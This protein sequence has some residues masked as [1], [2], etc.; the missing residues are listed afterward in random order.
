M[1]LSFEES[2]RMASKSVMTTSFMAIQN[3]PVVADVATMD[4][5]D[6]AAFAAVDS[7]F[8]R[9]DKYV[10]IDDYEDTVYSSIDENRN[11][12]VN[13]AQVD[14]TQENNG[15][16]VPFEMPRFYDGIDLM[17]MTIQIHYMNASNEENYAAPINVTFND[18]K[19][20]FGW[21]LSDNAT[22][23]DGTLAFELMASGAVTIPNSS[24][25]K[26]YLWRSRPNGK[27]NVIKSL[28]G[29]KMTDPTGDDWYTSFLATMNQKVGEA[30]SAAAEAKQSANDAKNAVASVDKKLAQYYKK[31]E[32]DG[33]VEMLRDEINAVDGL[34]NFDVKYTPETQIIQ[35]MNGEQEISRITLSTDPSVDWVTAYNKTVDAKIDE[36][37]SPVQ[38]TLTE[39]K[40]TLDNLKT[41]V[42]DLPTTL[43]SDYYNKGATDKLLADKAD[44][45]AVSGFTTDIANI[46]S[47]ISSIQDSVDTANSDIAEIQEKLKDFNPE[48]SG[49]EYDITYEDSKLSLLENG[50]V[51]T[52]VVIQGG[53]GGTGGT[54]VITIER[55]DG[56]ALTVIS[57]DAAIINY[58]FRSV[59][60]SGDDTGNAT[61]T[62]YVG[63]TKVATQTIVQG[64]NS[65]DITQYLH[66]GDNNIKLSVV[67][68]VGSVGT[69]TW[70]INVI[71]FYIESI[72]D[73]TLIYSDEVTFRYTPYG[74][75]S[76]T[77]VFTL[78]G[79]QVGT[80]TTT[81]TGRQ[82]TYTLPLQKHGAHLLE[83]HMTAE[84]NGNTVT[85]NKIY[86][87]IMWVSDLDTTPIISC[88]VRNY[89]TKQYSNIAITYT[90][91]D[92]SSSTARVTL[93]VDGITT[94]TLSVGRT[95]QTW[96]FKSAAI[97]THVL[98]I[99][100]GDT[101]KTIS[102]TVTELGITIEPVKTNLAFDFNPA[103]KTNA[104]ENRLWTDGNT[105]MTVSDNFDWSNG[106]YQIDEDGD[107]YFCVKSGTT[108]T[109]DYKLFADD[110][111]KSGKNFKLI[112][113]TANVRNYDA[114]AVTCLN[115]N[116]GLNI[117]AQKITLTSEQNSID[118]PTCEDDFMEFEFNILPD[119]QY[120][121]MVLWLDGIPCK[122]ELYASS[123]NFTQAKPVGI[124]IGSND[125]DVQVYRMKSY[126]MNLTDD[127]I[128]DNFIADAKNAEE[129]I[130][131]YTRND[132]TDVSGELNP[133]LLAEKCPNL[134][135]IKISAPTFTTGKKN[136]VPN[137]TI[138]HIYKNGRAVED[139]WIATG[140]HK[141]QGT[142]SNAYGESGRNI[143][144]DCSG[145]FT[146]GDESTGSKYAFTENSVGEKYFNIKVNVASSENANNALLADEFNEFN[147][148]IRQARKD[149]PKVRDTMAF[150]PC[151][152]FIQ[153]TDTTNAT[154][155]KDGQ[156]HFYACGDFGNSK[157]NSDTMGMDPNNHKEVIVEID[158]NTDAQTRFLSGDF[159]EETWDG[160]HSF[161]FRYI[162]K[163]CSE[164]EI[165]DAKNAWIRVQN[166]VVNAD[167]EEFKKN[168]ENYFVKDSALFHYL[169]TERHTMVDNR[170]KN[171]FPHTSDLVHWDF[172]FDYDNDTA[173]GNDN[174]GGL[175]LTYG[176]EDMDTIGTKS[177]FNAH[178]SKLWCKIRDLFADDLAKMFLNRESALAWSSTR[179]L[180]KFEDYQDVKP[181]RLWV[182][183]MRRK[184]FRTYEDNGTTSYL[185]MMHGNKRHQR[186]QFQR[187]QEKYMASKYTGTTCT[188][189][190]MTIRG[191]TPTNWTGVRPDGTFHITPYADTYISVRYGSNPVKMR[192]KRGQTYEVPCPIE[193]MNDTEVYIYNASIIQS[194]G[195]ISGFYP[196][197]VDFSHGIKLTDLQ[198]GSSVEGYAN[199]NMTDFAVGNNTLLE[200]LNLQNVPNL[201]KSIN[202]TG[203]VNLAEFLANGSGV[204]GVAFAKGGKIQKATLP[205]I[206]NLSVQNLRY[207]TDFSIAS[208]A[209]ITTL[210]VEDC[211]TIDLKEMLP[212]CTSLN[213]V[214][215]TGINWELSDTT[216]LDK[217]YGMTGLDENGYNSDHSV[218]EGIVHLPLIRE[219]QLENFK[220]QWPDLTIEYNTLIEQY[221]W[222][223]V[224]KDGSVLDIQYVDKGSKAVD[225]TTRTDN[226][227]S[228]PTYES[229]ISTDFTFKGWDTELAPAFSNETVTAVYTESVR[230]YHVRYMNHGNILQDTEAPYGSLVLYDGDIP[231]YTAEE[232]AFKFYLFNGWDKGGYVN[233]EKDINAVFDSC[234]Y[235]T[236]YFDGKELK[237]LR[238]VE[239][240]TMNQVG[241][242]NQVVEDK[243]D[244][245][246]R[247]GNDF[248][249][250][251]IVENV[252]ISRETAFNGSNYIDTGIKLLNED[253][254]WVIAVDYSMAGSNSRNS[255][256]MQC[257]ETNGTNGF[258]LWANGLA[259]VSWGTG[260]TDGASFDT[261]DMLVLRHI[262]GEN[263]VH[264]YC[265]N[266]YGDNIN[267][268]EIAK[269][270]LTKT[271]ATL[272]LG[273]A[274]ADDGA[275]ENFATGVIYW[276]KLW[277]ADLG[278]AACRQLAAWTHEEF[279][280]EA[281]GFKRYYLSNSSKRSSLTFLQKTTLGKKMALSQASSNENGWGGTTVRTYLDSRIVKALPIGWQQLIKQVKVPSSAGGTSTDI[282]TADSYFFIPSA[283]EVDPTMTTEPYVNEGDSISFMTT[284]ES[285]ACT[286]LDGNKTNYWTRSP[287][288]SYRN[289]FYS[290]SETG[291]L[292]GYLFPGDQAGIRLMFCV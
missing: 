210:T 273:C 25:T 69:K 212:K 260:S 76:K 185:P 187:Y 2:K 131:R 179:I 132:I 29:K 95:M 36:K 68:N 184:Y 235:T 3:E 177:V 205:A 6:V 290:V 158:N 156:W 145:G 124:T 247:M 71:E 20:R 16:I 105:K 12:T 208:Y 215:V 197:Y 180:K 266:C 151:V 249:Y 112:F 32:V 53:G 157:K 1:A 88:A 244:I 109:I 255:T 116:I 83:V 202:L 193:A 199:T 42:G 261:R 267:Y 176:Y 90:V 218:I 154:V 206:S 226:P 239:I 86:K 74:N 130:D 123:D 49:K 220:A 140:S 82:L 45:T 225:P 224:N 248:T 149:N 96:T 55:L 288:I 78:D 138:Q 258:R 268:V 196:G 141:G 189:D 38:N 106:G 286:D 211:P 279:E 15:Q 57:G 18:T 252:I 26:S 10:W 201:K 221:T 66:S 111:K 231:S 134:R 118:L 150:Y 52:T 4:L 175:T 146:F 102:V 230:K 173:M 227:I 54:S 209:N 148:Y 165:Q 59:D 50:G 127:E 155:F 7:G 14:V 142:S 41:E 5:N 22:A 114:T 81:V 43:Q 216:L 214:R 93:A 67:D 162:N 219:K 87:D 101:V 164:Q 166:W 160:D 183:D 72:F 251:D 46:K 129:M 243:D 35:F 64:K 27:L 161:E 153:E 237:N 84:I 133:D 213:R 229:T 79:V 91:Y 120:N 200:H 250:D 192:G 170:A 98:T 8:T 262:K 275:Y 236:G 257:Y 63:N 70:S 104:D 287:F 56:S 270:R 204:T 190:D 178:D 75:I 182:M 125:C 108:A 271:D 119:S 100:C 232:T 167:D 94:S 159:S 169:F 246:I 253:R 272:V 77:I 171:V 276:A 51:K 24:T 44:K 194:I 222:T 97:G 228:I 139:N 283:I 144:I 265:A 254:D 13:S 168:F 274:K 11:I 110:A 285:R 245:T 107:T 58:N 188:S 122:V 147:P 37:L 291:N 80:N 89:T 263:S 181:E 31:T 92:P 281:C 34:A 103:G 223:F 282:V 135:I 117:Q 99:T 259:K 62:W 126:M 242:A 115:G 191:Y 30:Q 264:I 289:Y 137:T 172:C 234:A 241:I 269:N 277:Y 33:F 198:I 9:S 203:C 21:L 195:D 39:T 23:K 240:Y 113:K 233:G 278:D 28:A 292:Y 238:P 121:E 136:E 217:L 186:R 60:N 174:E 73:D 284:N 128:L 143:D 163:N 61:G 85:S 40:E 65:F 152:V 17:G 19:I 207:L 47:N 48:E 280:F 256:L